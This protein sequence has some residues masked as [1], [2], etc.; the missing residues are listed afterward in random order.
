MNNSRNYSDP[1]IGLHSAIW[2]LLGLAFILGGCSESKIAP[3]EPQ[4][5]LGEIQLQKLAGTGQ[6][7]PDQYIV[8]FKNEVVDPA[9]VAN[10]MAQAHALG[11]RHTYTAALKGFA[12]V[13]PPARLDAVRDDPRVRYVTPDQ[14]DE[15]HAQTLPTGINR[16]EADLNTGP[17]ATDPVD[18]DIAI[19]DTGIDLNHPDLNVFR[20]VSFAGG[21]GDDKNGHGTHVAGTAAALDNEIGVVGVAPG[22][23]LWAVQ[24]CK[25]GG[26]CFRSD[27]IAG[28]DYVTK[29]AGEI[30]VVNMSLGGSGSDDGNCGLTNNDPEHEAICNAVEAGVVFVVSAGNSS[31]DAANSVP[32]AY[33]EVITVS[34]LADFDGLAG[35][36]GAPTCRTDEDD[37]FANF[38]NF[39]ADVDLMA[40]GVCILSTWN[41]GGTNTISGTSMSSPHVTGTVGL[42][43]ALNGRATNTAGVLAIRDAL[44]AAGIAQ[45]DLDCGL[46]TFDDP[47]NFAEP[48]V[49]ANTTN[50]G[51]DGT[52]EVATPPT[53]VTDIAL[54][55]VS[56]PASVVQGDVV[57]VDVTVENVGNQDVTSDITVTLT[58]TPPAGGTAGTVSAPQTIIGGLTAG[59][60]AILT[61]TWNTDV[62]S[63]GDHTLTAS[64]DFVD[65]DATNNSLST[66]VTVNEPAAGT[67]P[68]VDACSPDNGNPGDR[69]TVAVTG[70]NFQDG[71]TADFGERVTVQ[72][73]TFVSSSQLDVKIKIHPKAASGPRD[74]TVT[75]PDG[76]S[77]TEVGCFTVN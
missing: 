40:P 53:P 23:R 19:I 31:A 45:N 6:A 50:V 39:G 14:V 49:F 26:F 16:I 74:V 62:A 10:D 36:A 30:E 24:V 48:I 32:A 15:L 71:A 73:I 21:K 43:I 59:A 70:S 51:G 64:H 27:I 34:A 41:D 47:D 37:S 68:V 7:I 52:C 33:D 25:P 55:G 8:V 1:K 66:I 77:G 46:S 67:A 75:N 18:V 58:D 3:T 2:F 76:Q 17:T 9:A 57:S 42:Y 5:E 22:A 29:N 20:N 63:T 61:F 28:I 35:G 54:T 12:A 65:D 69:L 56:A 4:E 13:I 38:S 11:L 60:S 44:V 72:E